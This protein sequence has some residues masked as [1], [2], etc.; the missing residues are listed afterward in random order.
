MLLFAQNLTF[1]AMIYH[2]DV[3]LQLININVFYFNY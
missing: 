3:K 1:I 2:W